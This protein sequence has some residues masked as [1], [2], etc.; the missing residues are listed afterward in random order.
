LTIR[1]IILTATAMLAFAANSLLC[2]LALGQLLIDAASFTSTRAVAGA[3]TLAVIVRLRRSRQETVK[4]D[5]RA[6]LMLF[7]YMAFFSFA[8]LSLAAGTGALILF[9]AVQLTMFIYALRAGERF[10][11]L[12]WLGLAVAVAGLI[13]LVLPGVAAPD[14]IGAVLMAVAGVAWG[15]YS[16]L[17]RGADPLPAT[18]RNFLYCVPLA[19]LTSLVFLGRYEVSPAGL[20]LA[21]AS[22]AL[23]SG[24]G[25]VIWYAALGGLTATRAATVQLSVPAIA[26]LGGTL[27][28]AEPVTLRLLLASAATLGGVAVVLA[29]RAARQARA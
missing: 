29:Q 25:Y 22:G 20:A 24:C 8:Y 13:Y 16:L 4:Q 26:A 12:S 1:T 11:S 19:L 23:A 7:V 15:F 27:L 21:V 10:T 6:A 9:G 2:R 18:A 14:P 17:G 28:L 3:L 5:W